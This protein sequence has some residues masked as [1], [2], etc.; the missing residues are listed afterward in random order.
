ML[1]PFNIYVRVVVLAD[2]LLVGLECDGD[3]PSGYAADEWHQDNTGPPIQRKTNNN[4]VSVKDAPKRS[5]EDVKGPRS[6][7]STPDR[8]VSAS[9]HGY[10]LRWSCRESHVWNAFELLQFV[11][12][13]FVNQ[14]KRARR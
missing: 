9:L 6:Y 14:A 12:I 7:F 2:E 3:V 4:D 10:K 1:W 11:Q 8:S 13:S 5:G